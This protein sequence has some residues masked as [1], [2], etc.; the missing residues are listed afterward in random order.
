M[1]S[2]KDMFGLGDLEFD[3]FARYFSQAV[4][5]DR[6]STNAMIPVQCTRK[7]TVVVA[8]QYL[9]YRILAFLPIL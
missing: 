3:D 4:L 9:L 8:V 6:S 1:Q 2:L 7:W 5:E